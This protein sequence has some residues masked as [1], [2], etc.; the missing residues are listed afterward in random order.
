[1]NAYQVY[2]RGNLT[3]EENG[4]L[5]ACASVRK[6]ITARLTTARHR[7]DEQERRAAMFCHTVSGIARARARPWLVCAPQRRSH[8]Q[9]SLCVWC[10][11]GERRD[12]GGGVGKV[13]RRACAHRRQGC[14]KFSYIPYLSE[15]RVVASSRE[16]GGR[17]AD[18][19]VDAWRCVV[20]ALSSPM[21]LSMLNAR[22]RYDGLSL[23]VLQHV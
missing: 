10:V 16:F 23:C 2:A 6:H 4:R 18:G 8:N 11:Q 5:H 17:R 9:Q 3:G 22:I 19:I 1:M 7:G 12:D 21:T 15:Q 20:A 14:M 13:C